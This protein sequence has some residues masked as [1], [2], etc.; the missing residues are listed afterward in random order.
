MNPHRTFRS[1]SSCFL[2]LLPNTQKSD[3]KTFSSTNEPSLVKTPVVARSGFDTFELPRFTTI[4]GGPAKSPKREPKQS[5]DCCGWVPPQESQRFIS[6]RF[7]SCGS[8]LLV[9]PRRVFGGILHSSQSC[10]FAE[11][12]RAVGR[13]ARID[14][15]NVRI[16]SL[17]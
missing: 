14:Y 8:G 7:C 3:Y 17:N 5:F 9:Q 13:L 2:R 15:T 4:A 1:R 6:K 16:C 12:E 11:K 10:Q